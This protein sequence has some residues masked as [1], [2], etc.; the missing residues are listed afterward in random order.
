MP[1][2]SGQTSTAWHDAR[3]AEPRL[4]LQSPALTQLAA[5]LAALCS[6]TITKLAHL[7]AGL[8]VE[9]ISRW[10]DDGASMR[11]RP[12]AASLFAMPEW[13]AE[14]LVGI[15]HALLFRVLDVMYGGEGRPAT[16]LRLRELTRLELAVNARLAAAIATDLQALLA[17]AAPC[18]LVVQKVEPAFDP[19][20]FAAG[21]GDSVAIT[22]KSG[23]LDE[24]IVLILPA[25]CVEQACK[26]LQAS[27]ASVSSDA[28]PDWSR[29][30]QSHVADTM[31]ELVAAL[32]GPSLQLGDVAGLA[33]GSLIEIDS[34]LFERLRVEADR[35]SIFEGRLGQL[36]AHLAVS[37]EHAVAA[38]DVSG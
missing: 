11:D 26:R 31:V 38:G 28:D 6:G 7:D 23:A 14:A 2:D 20:S 35:E 30:L 8:A 5:E 12:V 37:I 36:K 25:A 10:P 24:R 13:R 27:A 32:Q 16:D 19:V 34:A 18:S 3:K 29:Q 21:A 22:L 15:E 9:R 4:K 1:D 17:S 33:V